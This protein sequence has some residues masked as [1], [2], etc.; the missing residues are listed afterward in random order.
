[1]DYDPSNRQKYAHLTNNCLV[2]KYMKET[3]KKEVGVPKF[4]DSPEK[5]PDKASDYSSDAEEG[6]ESDEALENIWGCE[7]FAEWLK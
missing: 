1:M 5:F 4:Q 7:D 2:K 6:E 3:G